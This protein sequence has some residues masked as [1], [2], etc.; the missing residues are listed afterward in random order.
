MELELRVRGEKYK[1]VFYFLLLFLT[2][3]KHSFS[4]NK[5]S[6]K[7]NTQKFCFFNTLKCVNKYSLHMADKPQ[8]LIK[9]H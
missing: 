2:P 6:T 5:P 9:T 4:I 7:T 1:Q 3:N 8:Q